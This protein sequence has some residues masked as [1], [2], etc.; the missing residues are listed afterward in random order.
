MRGYAVKTPER[1]AEAQ[2]LRAAGWLLRELAERYGVRVQTVQGWLSDPD[3]TQ[4]RSRKD[5]YARPCLDCGGP[6]SGGEGRREEPRCRPCAAIKK[7]V[8]AKIWTPAAVI[9]AIEEWAHMYGEPPAV[10]DWNPTQARILNDEARAQR[11]EDA[12]GN[13]P[14]AHTVRRAFGSWAT[15]L[16]AAGFTP[17]APHGGAGNQ[18]RHRNQR[19]AA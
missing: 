7:G 19:A 18:Y 15:A 10:A 8:E 16:E 13:W 12:D 11:F 9:L 17:R 14:H 6:T 4:L 5:S 2:R 1:V 3:G